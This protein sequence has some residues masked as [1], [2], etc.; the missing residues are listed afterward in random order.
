MPE[1]I[2]FLTGRLAEQPLRRTL[3]VT[4]LPCA[5][6][7]A[8]MPIQVAALMTTTWIARHFTLPP[9]H[10]RR[11]D[12]PPDCDRIMIPGYCAG[13]LGEIERACGV[14]VERGPKDLQDIPLHF[15]QERRRENYGAYSVKLIAEVQDALQLD[16]EALLRRAAYY[17][18]SGADIIDLGITP[19]SSPDTVAHAVQVLKKA[20]YRVSVD[21]L[22][23]AIILEADA[24]GVDYVLSLNSSNLELGQRLR[25]TPV[26]IPDDGGDVT[27]LWRNAEQ[28]W[29]WGVECILDPILQPIGFGFSRSLNDLYRT[30]E[31]YPEAKLMMGTHH[32]SELTD[33]DTTGINALLMGIAQELNLTFILTTEVAPWARGSVRELDIARRLM[34]YAVTEGVPPKRLDERL[35]TV[36]ESRLRYPNADD[37]RQM[38]ALITD[39]NVRIFVD[40]S[41]IYAFNADHFAV[42]T[43]IQAIFAELEV[44]EPTHAFYLGHELTKARLAL[45]L[46]KNYVQDEPLRWGYLTVEEP[47]THGRRVKLTARRRKARDP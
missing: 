42:G 43:D 35:L 9:D 11:V 18:E 29:E 7:V 28:L 15:G 19:G 21:S 13:D 2:V 8:V 38:H 5:Y 32:L 31:R 25:A 23:P 41:H 46:G 20:G 36:K 1:K 22:D 16:D 33:A 14:P 10:P 26:V 47:P 3:A 12:L 37:L 44:D 4:P 17:R 24:A 27:T 34:Y 45:H 40:G 39:P 6:E 30:R